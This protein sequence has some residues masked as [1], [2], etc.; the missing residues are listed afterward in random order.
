MA[1]STE[2]YKLFLDPINLWGK[3]GHQHGPRRSKGRGTMQRVGS[4]VALLCSQDRAGPRSSG[5][6]LL[7]SF[8]LFF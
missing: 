3:G 1:S 2:L 8:V 7:L 4:Y 5:L 6:Q